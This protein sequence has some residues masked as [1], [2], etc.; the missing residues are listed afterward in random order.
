MVFD[1]IGYVLLHVYIHLYPEILPSVPNAI[2]VI[3]STCSL[4]Q[5][6]FEN[7]AFLISLEN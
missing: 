7:E 6:S 1:E 5:A 4:P 2:S 3:S